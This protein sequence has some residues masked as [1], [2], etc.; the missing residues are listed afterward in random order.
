MR[1]RRYCQCQEATFRHRFLT[2]YLAEFWR[3]SGENF[4]LQVNGAF[5]NHFPKPVS[6]LP[7][8]EATAPLLSSQCSPHDVIALALFHLWGGGL[9]FLLGATYNSSMSTPS[10]LMQGY[11][12]LVIGLI[13]IC[14]FT[15]ETLDHC[16]MALPGSLMKCSPAIVCF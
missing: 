7:C 2:L 3:L 5:D 10:S 14:S 1:R 11:L 15:E 13:Q 9:N 6:Q 12:S 16:D 8:L 4:P